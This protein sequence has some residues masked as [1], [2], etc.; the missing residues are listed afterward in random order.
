[1]DN[2]N[3]QTIVMWGAR[4]GVGTTV[5]ATQ[6]A[7]QHPGYVTLIDLAGDLDTT[8]GLAK[9]RRGVSELQATDDR[10]TD[11]ILSAASVQIAS[12]VTLIPHGDGRG[13]P[14]LLGEGPSADLAEWIRDHDGVVIVDAGAG[15][16]PEAL[17]EVA[18]DSLAVTRLG[19]I[20]AQRLAALPDPPTAL[21]VVE[22]PEAWLTK[23]DIVHAAR[24][25]IYAT[26]PHDPNIAHAI[27]TGTYLQRQP[28]LSELN[29]M[30]DVGEPIWFDWPDDRYET[31]VERYYSEEFDGYEDG[32]ESARGD[33]IHVGDDIWTQKYAD[34]QWT[35]TLGHPLRHDAPTLDR[36]QRVEHLMNNPRRPDRG[37]QR[38]GDWITGLPSRRAIDVDFGHA[39]RSRGSTDRWRLSW[40]TGSGELHTVN[41]R[42]STVTVLGVFPNENEVEDSIAGWSKRHDDPNGLAWL[43]AVTQIACTDRQ[44]GPLDH[45]RTIPPDPPAMDLGPTL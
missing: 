17:T 6:L 36:H 29:A 38:L 31:T 9:Q 45:A 44:V 19:R 23:D 16:P 27:D 32:F 5:A 3:S 13:A 42:T 26:L 8:L 24:A 39:W 7:F 25:G 15:P 28:H 35:P 4:G 11:K 30:P 1:M 40:N 20:D 2:T 10:R 37:T 41:H 43:D 33:C 34:R 18:D 22:R 14:G 12:R 21:I